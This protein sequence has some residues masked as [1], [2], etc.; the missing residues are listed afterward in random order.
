MFQNISQCVYLRRMSL[1]DLV[2]C[3]IC[4]PDHLHVSD[5]RLPCKCL[6]LK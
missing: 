3:D 4:D 6:A 2:A 1:V 5:L